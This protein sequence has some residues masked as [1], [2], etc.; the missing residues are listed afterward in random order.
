M[1]TISKGMVDA[2][3][4]SGSRKK[5]LHEAKMAVSMLKKIIP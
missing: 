5:R 3:L 4:I 1:A 2:E